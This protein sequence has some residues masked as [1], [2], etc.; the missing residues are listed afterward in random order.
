MPGSVARLPNGQDDNG[1]GHVPPVDLYKVAVEE[2]RFQ[3]QY[4]WSRTQYMLALNVAILAA[5]VALGSRPG[6][7]A[8]LVFA[9]GAVASAM[10]AVMVRTQHDYYRAAR[11]RMRRVETELEVPEPHR[12]DTTSTLGKRKRTVSVNQMVYLLLT[13]LLIADCVGAGIILSR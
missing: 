12:I 5:A 11:D 13:A 7:G 6:K 10:A 8:A 4:N 2:Y 9:L 3:A 1:G